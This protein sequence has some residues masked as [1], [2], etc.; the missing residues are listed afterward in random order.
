MG[1]RVG[2]GLPA[3]AD[4]LRL[5]APL[6]MKIAERLWLRILSF[7]WGTAGKPVA[8]RERLCDFLPRYTAYSNRLF[9]SILPHFLE[10][11]ANG[12]SLATFLGGVYLAAKGARLPLVVLGCFLP[13]AA[14]HSSPHPHWV[15]RR[16][17]RVRAVLCRVEHGTGFCCLSII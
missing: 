2:G 7:F 13:P 9:F 16:Q 15:R 1:P 8:R 3:S 14:R 10:T 12:P 17:H 5:C 6:V 4:S 11:L